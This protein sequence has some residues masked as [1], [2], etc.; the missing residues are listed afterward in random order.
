MKSLRIATVAALFATMLGC[1][2]T[3]PPATSDPRRVLPAD[4]HSYANARDVSVEHLSLDLNVDFVKKVL[5][6]TATLS[7]VNHTGA[8]ELVLD[9]SG[10]GIAQVTLQ[11]GGTS[12]AFTLAPPDRFLGSALHIPI[13]P[14]TRQVTVRYSTSPEAAGLQWLEPS[15]T[16]GKRQP[17]LFTQSESIFARTWI[18]CQDS[19]GVRITYDATIRVPAQLMAVMSADGNPRQRNATGVYRFDMPQRIPAYLVALA[20]G[21]LSFQALDA[22]SGVYAEPSV[23]PRAA[24]EL[25]DTP[26]MI[27]AAES[28]YGPYR[29]GRYDV[30]VLPPSFP[31]GGMENPRLTFATPTILAGDRSLVSL[32]SHEL[33]HS[34]SG[35]LVTNATWNDFWLNEGFTDYFERRIDEKLYGVEFAGELAL[36]GAGELREEMATMAPAD[37]A[38]HLQLAGRDPDEG[39]N[40]VPYEKGAL[41]VT[42]LERAAGRERF[43]AFLRKYFDTFAF[44]S[45]DT[46]TFLAYLRTELFHGD[47]AAMQP[48][49]IEQWVNGPGLPPNAPVTTSAR[50]DA[51]DA[52]ARRFTA[53]GG[54]AGIEAGSWTTNEWLRFLAEVPATIGAARIGELD[55]RFHLSD[56]GNAEILRSWFT[57]A[58]ENGYR[59]A[60]PQLERYLETIGRRRLIEPLY[61]ALVKTPEGK[62]FAERVYRVARPGYHAIT[63]GSI[64]KIVDWKG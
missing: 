53:G 52:E 23:L 18:P 3:T 45:M 7:I 12:S 41:F 8:S 15:Q 4:P 24:Y 40:A 44:Q 21:D 59:D 42:M 26:K 60:D 49:L 11:P 63:R 5:S 34:W 10:L 55:R 35:N 31:F 36:L 2:S 39:S 50:F 51:I 47:A 54:A 17:F 28:L 37:T 46:A 6:G 62:A 57:L 43:D 48:L 33:A 29:W 32:V 27:A 61:T 22:R 16:A 38:L 64:D 20:V 56:S 9:S 13:D 58:I 14:S 25:A 19:P 30:L 1:V